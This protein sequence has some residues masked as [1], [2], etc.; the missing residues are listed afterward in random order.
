MAVNVLSSIG[1]EDKKLKNDSTAEIAK[2]LLEL[3]V[4]RGEI[5]ETKG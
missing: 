5:K 4:L 1:D 2:R 3:Y